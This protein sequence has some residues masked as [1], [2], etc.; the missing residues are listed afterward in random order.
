VLPP[1]THTPTL[2][3]RFGQ[4]GSLAAPQAAQTL[5]P[6]VL[7][8]WR[9]CRQSGSTAQHASVAA[10]QSLQRSPLQVSPSS[11]VLPLQQASSMDPHCT[12]VEVEVLQTASF[13]H[14]PSQQGSSMLPQFSQEPSVQVPRSLPQSCVSAT[15]VPPTQQP[16]PLH[17][18]LSQ[19]GPPGAPHVEHVPS[20]QLAC[21]SP[22]RAPSQ[23]GLPTLPQLTQR[24]AL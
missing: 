21:A 2:H 22:Q 18:L 13:V 12:H 9:P 19:H 7:T 23:H 6:A 11:Q 1:P 5:P 3:T 16:P 24:L 20:T 4:Q 10:P 8:H 17:V 14:V 15:Q